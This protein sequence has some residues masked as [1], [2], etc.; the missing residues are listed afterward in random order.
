[1]TDSA[2]RTTDYHRAGNRSARRRTAL[3]ATRRTRPFADLYPRFA[4]W[5]RGL[6]RDVIRIERLLPA[7]AFRIV[8]GLLYSIGPDPSHM[9][10]VPVHDGGSLVGAA[11]DYRFEERIVLQG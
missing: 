11:G 9:A 7:D 4:P 2:A 8:S 3:V 10:K 5:Y 1:M 6:S